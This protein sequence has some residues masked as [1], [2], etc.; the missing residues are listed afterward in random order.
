[1]PEM[2]TAAA[3]VDPGAGAPTTATRGIRWLRF[4]GH[5]LMMLAAM[6]VGMFTL[7]PAYTLGADRLGYLDPPAQLPVL[8]AVVMGLAMTVP[9]AALMLGHRHGWRMV[10]EMAAAMLGPTL[11][12]VAASWLRLLPEDMVMTVSH[13]T[14]VPAMLIAML[15]RFTHYAGGRAATA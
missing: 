4:G 13:A 8:S 6:Y 1:M 7:Y 14:M 2:S 12:A 9:M 15:A 10:N 5:F 3:A 11:L